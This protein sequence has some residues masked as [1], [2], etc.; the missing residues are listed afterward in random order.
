MKRI[1]PVASLALLGACAVQTVPYGELIEPLARYDVVFLG[2]QHDSSTGHAL[3][4]RV[5]EQLHAQRPDIVLAMEMFERDVQPTLDDYLAG[6]IDEAAFLAA[7][8]PWPNY[9]SDYR[10]LVEFA[11]AHELPV[12]AANAPRDRAHRVVSEGLEAVA[13]TE[14]VAA[15]ASAPRDAYWTKFTAEMGSHGGVSETT[16]AGFY[17]AQC[18][19]DD[20]MAES[21]VR[22]FADGAR[23]LVVHVAGSF[24]VEGH[25]GTAAR[26]RWRR[27]D[28]RLAVV[29]MEARSNV[30]AVGP[31]EWVMHVATEPERVTLPAVKP[32]PTDDPDPAAEPEVVMETESSVPHGRPALG[33]MPDYEAGVAG[34]LVAMLRAGGPAEQAG[35]LE[36]DV[37]VRIRDVPIT[38]VGAYME[39]L[40]NLD[41]GSTVE[42]EVDRDGEKK[43][44]QI[45]VGERIQ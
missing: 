14:F 41:V 18:L 44:I 31:D 15:E 21:I 45:K 9:A 22:C 13:G 23:P 25:L 24:H 38:D 27:P 3:Q 35:V 33:F 8:R 10:P 12:I 29:S 16:M 17:A 20:T 19:K 34:V 30:V 42:I 7:S 5:L 36:G 2:E 43:V 39:E 4:R 26:V 40:G 28:L 11:K 6:R 32:A 1:L 37:I